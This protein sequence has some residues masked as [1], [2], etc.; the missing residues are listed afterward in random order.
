V[1]SLDRRSH[2]A[3]ADPAANVR[4]AVIEQCGHE[5]NIERPEEFN[6][7]LVDFLGGL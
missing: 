6:R 4:A 1:L 7:I 5:A 3:S 2:G